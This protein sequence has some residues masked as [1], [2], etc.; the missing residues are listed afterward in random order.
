MKRNSVN[1]RMSFFFFIN[2]LNIKFMKPG[3]ENFQ[4]TSSVQTVTASVTLVEIT[5]FSAAIAAGKSAHVRVH[6][7]FSVGASGGF[8][9]QFVVPAAPANFLA[10]F[11][12]I[13]PVTPSEIDAVQTTSAAFAN[14]LAVAGNHW[15]EAELDITNGSA[16]GTIALQFACNSAA[17]AISIL[18][19]AWME[20]VYS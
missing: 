17:G 10:T 1:G 16:A 15:L 14:A 12:V 3:I 20:V 7:P 13:D 19:G 9:F 18:Q 11:A 6:V 8:K 4:R 5:G 2:H